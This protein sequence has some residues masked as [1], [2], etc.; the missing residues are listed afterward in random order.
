M[1]TQNNNSQAPVTTTPAPVQSLTPSERFTNAVL[2]EFTA[3][4]GGVELTSF[5]RKLIQNYFIKLDG[6]LSDMEIKRLGKKEEYRDP[7]EC[8]WKNINLPKLAVDV[9]A[10]SSVGLDALQP[11]HINPIPF[12]NKLTGKYDISFIMGYKGIEIKA[13]KYGVDV[14]D[15]VTVEVVYS[16]DHFK[17]FKKDRNNPVESYEFEIINDFDRG[18]IIGG[19][20]FHKFINHP[21][22]NKLKVFTWND[23]LKRIPEK[24]A[25][26]FWGGTKD[27]WENGQ[28]VTVELDGWKDE[29]TFKTIYRAAYNCITIDSAK[30][31]EHL[32]KIIQLEQFN[33]DHKI[34]EEITQNANKEPVGFG[35]IQQPTIQNPNVQDI[36]PEPEVTIPAPQQTVGQSELFPE[37]R[38]ARF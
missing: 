24:A 18:D 13:T 19:F 27:K 9:V 23:I 38:Q 10:Y 14:P 34:E 37:Q 22:K 33:S 11:N 35:T 6:V 36:Q 15:E 30:I 4:N 12:K 5:Q 20:Y 31:D 25:A 16:N 2:S 21:E 3:S 1:S 8:S 7:I 28:K 29:M 26:E 32:M 17:S